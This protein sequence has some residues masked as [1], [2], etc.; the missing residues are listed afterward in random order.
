MLLRRYAEA[1]AAQERALKIAPADLTLVEQGALLALM[2]GDIER[3][4]RIAASPPAGVDP[5]EHIAYFATYEELAFLLTDEQRRRLVSL[6]PAPFGDDRGVW[7]L[8]VAQVY[9]LLRDPAKTRAYADSARL[10]F[11]EQLRDAP[12]DG[13]LNAVLGHALALAGRKAE[14]IR[15][16]EHG[17]AVQPPGRDAYFGPYI[18]HQLVRIYLLVGEPE[19]ALDRLEPLLRMPYTLTPGWLRV[20]PLFDPVRKHPRF[21]RL[22]EGTS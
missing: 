13:Q 19:R 8:S 6:S 3:A 12:D 18:Q 14:A 4:R 15:A 17:L 1:E 22:V 16:G 10:A 9:H 7:G 20:D 21:Q 2:Q 5:A 11:Q